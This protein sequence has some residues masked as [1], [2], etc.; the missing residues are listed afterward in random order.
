[1][2]ISYSIDDL[3]S[4]L[5]GIVINWLTVIDVYKNK[6]NRTVCLCKCKC[7]TVKEFPIKTIRKGRIKSC[8]CF[9]KLKEFSDNCKKWCKDNKDKV[10]QR[11]IKYKQWCES[12]SDKV[13]EQGIKHSQWFKESKSI[14]DDYRNRITSLNIGYNK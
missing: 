12:N 14:I 10:K 7:G 8:G 4:E 5:I 13:A 3:R 11:A 2:R 1:M 6:N 9:H